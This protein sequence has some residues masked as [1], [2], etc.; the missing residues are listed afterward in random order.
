DDAG[1]IQLIGNN[2]IFLVEQRFKQTAIGIE[3]RAIEDCVFRTEEL[4]E[5]FLQLLVNR[6]CTADEAY[7]GKAVAPAIERLPRRLYNR[8]MI[9]QT[10]IV[11]GAKVQYRRSVRQTHFGL[12]RPSQQT[13]AFV[14][15]GLFD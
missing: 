2:C 11:V 4:A 3:A 13:F 7:T 5:P 12:L 9:R 10:H 1:M 15:T 14:K 6:L 8:G